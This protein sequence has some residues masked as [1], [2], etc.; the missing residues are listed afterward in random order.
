MHISESDTIMYNKETSET[1]Y[2][3][4][5]FDNN[6]YRQV[7]SR[8]KFAW[9]QWTNKFPVGESREAAILNFWKALKAKFTVKCHKNGSVSLWNVPS[10]RMLF[11]L[12]LIFSRKVWED[13]VQIKSFQK[14]YYSGVS[15]NHTSKTCCICLHYTVV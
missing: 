11:D 2:L 14:V 13:K 7:L 10:G 5:S 8:G 9:F 6:R 3:Y 4:N 1:V 15:H 12:G